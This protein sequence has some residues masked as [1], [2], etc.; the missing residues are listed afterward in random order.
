MSVTYSLEL[1][2]VTPNF[3]G[4]NRCRVCVCGQFNKARSEQ[5]PGRVITVDH[6]RANDVIV[7]FF[8]F[9]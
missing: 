4:S 8:F 5:D 1:H 6:N 7:F 9:F 3:H 2:L